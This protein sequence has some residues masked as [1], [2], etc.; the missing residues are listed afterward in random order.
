MKKITL[1]EDPIKMLVN[2][3]RAFFVLASISGSIT[4]I[5][6]FVILLNNTL[7]YSK[8]SSGSQPL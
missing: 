2:N 7:N 4:L 8:Y 3:L 1:T 6:G 5:H